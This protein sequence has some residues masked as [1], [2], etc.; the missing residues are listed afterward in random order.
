VSFAALEEPKRIA[1]AIGRCFDAALY[2]LGHGAK[3]EGY[4]SH[5]PAQYADLDPR[6][7]VGATLWA[8]VEDAMGNVSIFGA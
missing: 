2:S 1:D 7:H 6:V 8:L 5:W 4:Y 3:G